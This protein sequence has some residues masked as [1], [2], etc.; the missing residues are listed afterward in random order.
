M[1]FLPEL[2]PHYIQAGLQPFPVPGTDGYRY[3]NTNWRN[4]VAKLIAV[5]DS[6]INFKPKD[7]KFTAHMER[8]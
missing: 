2:V 3:L 7:R 4:P 1:G 8:F 5:S 6:T